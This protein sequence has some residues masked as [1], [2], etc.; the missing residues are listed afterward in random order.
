MVIVKQIT[1]WHIGVF[2]N[3]EDASL[4]QAKKQSSKN[5]YTK[6]KITL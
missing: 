3:L 5:I 1:C 2:N 4:E 6:L